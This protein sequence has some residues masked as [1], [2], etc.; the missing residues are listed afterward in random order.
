MNESTKKTTTPIY[1]QEVKAILERAQ[2]GDQTVLDELRKLLTDYPELW[3]SLGDMGV[4]AEQAVV[5]LASGGSLL[6]Q[7]AVRMKLAD[8]RKDLANGKGSP[9]ERLLIDRIVLTWL[10]SCHGDLLENDKL[11]Q[12]NGPSLPLARV[13]DRAHNRLLASIKMLAIVRRLEL[14][15]P[16]PLQIASKFQNKGVQRNAPLYAGVGVEN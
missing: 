11:Q 1:P 7:E 14:V 12:G 5:R 6:A 15:S 16:S 3:Q 8:L 4:H 10:Q 13:Q 2:A 9:L